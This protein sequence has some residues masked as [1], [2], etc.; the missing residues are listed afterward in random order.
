MIGSRKSP[1]G[2]SSRSNHPTTQ[3]TTTRRTLIRQPLTLITLTLVLLGLVGTITG[4][5]SA[6]KHASYR[7]D[8]TVESFTACA[9]INNRVTTFQAP[10]K[11]ATTQPLTLVARNLLLC[12]AFSAVIPWDAQSE[13]TAGGHGEA[14]V[15]GS[16]C[17]GGAFIYKMEQPGAN[18]NFQSLIGFRVDNETE[19]QGCIIST[20]L[21]CV[22]GLEKETGRDSKRE[23]TVTTRPLQI[24]I[25]NSLPHDLVRTNGP[26]WSNALRSPHSDNAHTVLP[27]HTGYTGAL[28]AIKRTATYA[29]IYKV[30][31]SETD[32]SYNGLSF[33]INVD[34]TPTGARTGTCTPL[35]APSWRTVH[36]NV[37]FS[38]TN[39]GLTIATI[40]VRS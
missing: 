30:A 15:G 40:R 13:I 38:G 23:F 24:K 37:E 31:Y 2:K 36:C 6:A 16:T 20:Y 18:K 10:G 19:D 28:R 21:D 3:L 27:H 8:P 39:T 7:C 26:Y 33:A 25:V 22:M 1:I 32:T 12:N 4:T 14:L 29:T 5:A 34:V 11:L 9:V 17:A 35:R